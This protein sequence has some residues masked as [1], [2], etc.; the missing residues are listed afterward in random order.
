MMTDSEISSSLVIYTS[1]NYLIVFIE[2][3]PRPIY[4]VCLCESSLL[5]CQHAYLFIFQNEECHCAVGGSG[6]CSVWISVC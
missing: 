5:Y 3:T 4:S 2:V 1:N 6:H